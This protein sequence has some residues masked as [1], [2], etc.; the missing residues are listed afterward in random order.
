MDVPRGVVANE[1][2]EDKP[3]TPKSRHPAML[4]QA[5]TLDVRSLALSLYMGYAVHRAEISTRTLY[6]PRGY[7]RG[8]P[9]DQDFWCVPWDSNPERGL[10]VCCRLSQA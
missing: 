7:Q 5:V 4:P 1:G 6:T 10:R 2:D 3:S 9:A 8:Y